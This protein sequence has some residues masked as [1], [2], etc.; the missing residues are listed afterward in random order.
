MT[1]MACFI[2]SIL[3]TKKMTGIN[4][5]IIQPGDDNTIKNISEWYFHEWNIPRDKTIQKLKSFNGD[6]S[7]FQVLMKIND[8]PIAT[9]GLY[10]QVGLH[11]KEPRFK[12]YKNWLA[13][14]YTT[15]GNR[16]QGFGALICNYIENL[17]KDRGI[18]EIFLFTDTAEHL[19]TRLGWYELEKLPLGKRNIV[20]MKKDL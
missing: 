6:N 12:I 4:F 8:V 19:Y 3:V 5:Q 14:I 2:K 1:G 15:P 11:D 20:V 9:G 17:S 7:Q 16:R 13:L 10:N 18:K